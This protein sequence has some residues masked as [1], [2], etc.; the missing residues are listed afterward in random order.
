MRRVSRDLRS[1]TTTHWR[2]GF[3]PLVIAFAALALILAAGSAAANPSANLDQCANDPAPSPS[4]NG[5]DTAATQWVNGNLGAS[6][7]VYFEGDSIPYRLTMDNLNTAITH[8]VTI[9]WDTT[10]SSKHALDYLTTVN[11]SVTT[12]D[13]C[14]GVSG[15][16]SFTTFPIPA[17]PQVTGAGV[18]PIA[19]VFRLYGGTINSIDNYVYSTGTGFSG[20]K[21][22][23][24]KIHFTASVANPVLAWGGHISARKDWGANGSAVA[25]S[26]SPYHTRLLDLDGSG[27][28][29]D[30]SLSADAVIF[31]G[32]ITIIKDATPNGSTSFPYTASP[33][34]L[35]GFSLVDDGTS[36]NTK[37]FSNI[38]NFQTYTVAEGTVANWTLSFPNP[39]CSVS[40][41]NG[42]SQSSSLANRNVTINLAEGENV[43]CTFLNTRNISSPS[44]V[45]VANPQSVSLGPSG[46]VTLNDSATLSGGNNPGGSITFTLSGTACTS[47]VPVNGNGTY[48]ASPCTVSAVGTYTWH[49][50]YSGDSLNNSADDNGANESVVVGP[51]SPA[52]ATVANPQS[53]ALDSSG[54]AVL[55]DSA[56]LSGA[57]P[58]AGGSITFTLSGSACTSTVPVNGNGTYSA[59]PCTVNATGTYTW[60]AHYSGDG[61]NSAADDNGA[62]ES[63]VVT[64]PPKTGQITPTNTTCS[65]FNSGT[66]G[67]L[68]SVTY[69][70]QQGKSGPITIKNSQPGVFFYYIKLVAPA[71]SWSAEVTFSPGTPTWGISGIFAFDSS[72]NTWKN[73]TFNSSNPADV[74]FNFTGTTAGQTYIIAVKYDAK[75]IVGQNAPA[76]SPLAYTF[77]AKKNGVD[78]PNSGQT[79]NLVKTSGP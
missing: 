79:L 38:T 51:N 73:V 42:G 46:S 70:T 34:P 56:I 61:N 36:A 72:C 18:T 30:R 71:A 10:K 21:S 12:A 64:A 26:G 69:Q 25:I 60:H 53:V 54:S 65:A 43:T 29:Q 47:T 57:T 76:S 13:P 58:G 52:I 32:S 41:P 59:S 66:A 20:D 14:L 33:S 78:V 63:V 37:V 55:N 5:C 23:S 31:P 28:N 9:E 8:T 75:A 68:S 16:S 24:L 44:I 17:D 27:G 3:T 39:A 22:A 77:A 35:S 11:Q 40:S 48:S 4:N 74:T 15:C 19:G 2:W 62:N 6:K 45:T 67:T 7:S 49:A 50:H 1:R